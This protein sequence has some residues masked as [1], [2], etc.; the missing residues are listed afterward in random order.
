[1]S[2]IIPGKVMDYVDNG[3]VDVKISFLKFGPSQFKNVV[4]M[5][6]TGVIHGDGVPATIARR[7]RS[8][9]SLPIL[10]FMYSNTPQWRNCDESDTAQFLP[11]LKAAA[12]ATFMIRGSL[13]QEKPSWITHVD[14]N[15]RLERGR[16]HQK[17]AINALDTHSSAGSSESIARK[18]ATQLNKVKLR[19]TP[20][21]EAIAN[22]IEDGSS[23]HYTMQYPYYN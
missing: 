22:A 8:A 19:I 10:G 20:E 5:I 21:V 18:Y 7:I 6:R 16:Q 17:D 23:T 3:K 12:L 2:L 11:T 15:E 14:W 13:P 9:H 4:K 1:M